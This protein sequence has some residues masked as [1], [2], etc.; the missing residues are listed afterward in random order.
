M[1]GWA[2]RDFS[3]VRYECGVIWLDCVECGFNMTRLG[4]D[5]SKD[6]RFVIVDVWVERWVSFEDGGV[7]VLLMMYSVVLEWSMV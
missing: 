6:S 2:W 5:L 1:F 7:N 3:V 4:R